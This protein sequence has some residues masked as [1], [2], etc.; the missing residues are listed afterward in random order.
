MLA[1]KTSTSANKPMKNIN[2]RRV[3][4]DLWGSVRQ[5]ALEK[6][7]PLRQLIIWLLANSRPI[8]ASNTFSVNVS[9]KT[10]DLNIRG[11]PLEVWAKA[12]RNANRSG[13]LFR[14]YLLKL[15]TQN[16]SPAVGQKDW[17]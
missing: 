9:T 13:M 17:Q 10:R 12:R 6:D 11:V 5:A 7:I 4:I 16:F 15:I 14:D 1:L 3:P 8:T 2:I